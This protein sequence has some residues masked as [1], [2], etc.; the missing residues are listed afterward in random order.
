MVATVCVAGRT[1]DAGLEYEDVPAR[2]AADGPVAKAPNRIR[3]LSRLEWATAHRNGRAA[4]Q[5]VLLLDLD[6]FNVIVAGF[7]YAVSERLLAAVA[8][9]LQACVRS[10]D[11]V[12]RFGGDEFA[13]LLE[14]VESVADA[15]PVAE[16]ITQAL[17][18]P[19]TLEGQ[20]VRVTASI[21]VAFGDPGCPCPDDLLRAADVALYQAKARGKARYEVFEPGMNG[22]ALARLALEND[23][24]RALERGEFSVHYQPIACLATGQ[25]AEVE[26]LVRWHHPHRG[27]VPPAEFIPLA[28]QNGLIVQ[29]GQWVLDQACRQLR[30]WRTHYPGVP[31]LT[32][33]VNLSARQFQQ[34]D[35]ADVISGILRETGVPA[36]CLKLEITESAAVEDA[37]LTVATLWLLKGLGVQLAIDDFGTGYSSLSYLKRFP[38]DALKIDRSFVEGLGHHPEDTAIVH[39]VVAF[40]KALGLSVTAEGTETADQLAHLRG[41]GCDRAQGYYLARPLPADDITA[42]LAAGRPMG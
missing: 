19:F 40:A 24:R 32:M 29:V 41:L 1:A 4:A 15:I 18:A 8:E 12:T 22:R 9:R 38:V 16:R 7:G 36:G 34:P 35:L 11:T 37:E 28:E 30:A 21:G 23:L 13:V 14:G 39:A 5:A 10:G 33:S 25:I 20:E 42:L 17:D 6:N 27:L 2:A 26:A 3:F 31:P